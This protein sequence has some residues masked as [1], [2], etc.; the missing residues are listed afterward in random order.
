MQ[1]FDFGLSKKLFYESCKGNSKNIF[2]LQ[3]TDEKEVVFWELWEL[4][5]LKEREQKRIKV[6][7]TLEYWLSKILH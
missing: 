7:Q 3:D 5:G 6:G 2:F 4:N 1:F